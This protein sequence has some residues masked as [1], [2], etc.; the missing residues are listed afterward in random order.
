MYEYEFR[1]IIPGHEAEGSVHSQELGYV[2]GYYPRAGNLAGHYQ[3]A[4]YKLAD[5][6]ENYW[7]NFAKNGNPNAGPNVILNTK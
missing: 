2:F 4:D 6:M 7:T 5:L 1:R 3:D